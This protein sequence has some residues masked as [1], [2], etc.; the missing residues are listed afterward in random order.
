MTTKNPNNN[1]SPKNKSTPIKDISKSQLLINWEK[2]P[3]FNLNIPPLQLCN[4]KKNNFL[5]NSNNT[6]ISYQRSIKTIDLSLNM[7]I[8]GILDK[9]E[10]DRKENERIERDNTNYNKLV[11]FLDNKNDNSNNKIVEYKS[12]NKFDDFFSDIFN[13]NK[14]LETTSSL[15]RFNSNR[16]KV[17]A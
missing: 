13:K 3:T 15:F 2:N 16:F 6:I 5:D 7:T 14:E 8:N 1:K 11:T 10:K 9:L 4:G 12:N 17:L